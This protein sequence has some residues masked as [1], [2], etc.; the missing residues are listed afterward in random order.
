MMNP[1]TA[2]LLLLMLFSDKALSSNVS[3]SSSVNLVGVSTHISS[4]AVPPGGLLVLVVGSGEGGPAVAA[5]AEAAAASTSPVIIASGEGLMKES[6][7]ER[8]ERWAI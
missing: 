7:F 2:P 4:S 6:F 1:I 5:A 3:S 8:V